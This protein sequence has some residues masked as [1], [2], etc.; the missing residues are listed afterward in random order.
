MFF[1]GWVLYDAKVK[2]AE[3]Y[4][5]AIITRAGKLVWKFNLV[6]TV[7]R[8]TVYL[9]S[10][11]VFNMH[12]TSYTF[13]VTSCPLDCNITVSIPHVSTTKTIS[14]DKERQCYNFTRGRFAL[15]ITLNT[16]NAD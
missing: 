3:K 11:F 9:H 8:V 14:H 4:Y 2:T 6:L 16:L 7:L 1:A 10:V 13:S 5:S 15:N 12:I